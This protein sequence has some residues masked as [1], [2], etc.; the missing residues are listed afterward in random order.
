MNN[1][2]TDT[3]RLITKEQ[4]ETLYQISQALNSIT[5]EDSLINETL[6]LI[7]KVINAER[8]LFVKYNEET[9][10]FDIIGA[11]NIQQENIED[12]SMFSSGILQKVIE[13]KGTMPLS[14]CSKRP[15]YLAI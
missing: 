13:R 5:Y 7:I 6:D 2:Y 8:G 11:R 10:K 9:N 4:F 14:R 3:I 15:E 12:L 1:H